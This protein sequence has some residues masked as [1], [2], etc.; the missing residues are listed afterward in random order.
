MDALLGYAMAIVFSLMSVGSYYQWAHTGT[1]NIVTAAIAGQNVMFN[2]A[3]AE[4]VQDYAS[5]LAE[6]ATSSSPVT[7]SAST[8]I[9]AGYLPSGFSTTNAFGQ[10]WEAQVLQPSTDELE[11]L[12]LTTGGTAISDEIELVH[13]AAQVGA[14]GGFVPYS[15]QGGDS[16]M[17]S[18]YAR[19]AYGGWK[20]SLTSFTNP[21]S[22]HLASLLS[23]TSTATN[24]NYL[25]RVAVSGESQLNAMQTDLSMEDTSGSKHNINDADTVTAENFVASA[26]DGVQVGDSYLYGDSANTAVRQSGGF[27]VQNT[28]GTGFEP[29]YAG[30]ITA[31]GALTATGAISSDSTITAAGAINSDSTITAT[32]AITSSSYVAPG[33]V[34]TSGASCS[35]N[36]AIATNGSQTLFCSSGTWVTGTVPSGT[37][38]GSVSIDGYTGE[39]ATAS[40]ETSCEG[41]SIYSS[42]CPSGY[43]YESVFAADANWF[44][45]CVKT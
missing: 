10:T 23:F 12:V 5:T 35:P 21:G 8:L 40:T 30:A 37:I 26:G 16:T 42:G 11:T 17:S 43:T 13:I 14:Q 15:D 18:S 19:G 44:F 31:N 45:S 33:D 24:T 27:Y 25:Y 34:A 36:G 28:A 38:C 29:V 39:P 3:A 1:K 2:T 9:S 7:I 32:G 6:T 20:Q 22:G 41:Y 4:Y